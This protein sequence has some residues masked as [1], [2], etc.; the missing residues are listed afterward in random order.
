MASSPQFFR[1]PAAQ[2]RRLAMGIDSLTARRLIVMAEEYEA[3]L[4]KLKA[5][6]LK[7]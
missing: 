5:P 7:E 1:E 3:E 6:V 2:C 4:L